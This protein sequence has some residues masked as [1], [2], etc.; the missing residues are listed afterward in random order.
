M[1][2]YLYVLDKEIAEAIQK[3]GDKPITVMNS[4]TATVWVFENTGT[5]T[6][7]KEDASQKILFSNTLRMCF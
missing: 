6:F 4:G 3:N 2:K 5:Y 7:S 1:K